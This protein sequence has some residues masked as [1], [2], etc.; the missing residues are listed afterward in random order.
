LAARVASRWPDRYP[1]PSVELTVT[2][3]GGQ[4]AFRN[5]TFAVHPVPVWPRREIHAAAAPTRLKIDGKPGEWEGVPDATTFIEADS[6]RLAE[7]ETTVRLAR[8][9]KNLYVLAR[10]QMGDAKRFGEGAED[11]DDSD[12]YDEDE[13]FVVHL[14]TPAHAYTF[15]VNTRKSE[16]DARDGDR[17]WNGDFHSAV[18][19]DGDHW[20]A[21]LAIPLNQL[22]G[23]PNRVNFVHTDGKT[24][25]QSLWVPTFGRSDDANWYGFLTAP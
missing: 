24:E 11:R 16:Y 8:D 2:E 18:A 14:G 23:E 13:S 3:P 12:I 10:L 15:G 9:E 7:L 6:Q 4:P 22:D 1:L 5:R 20:Y 21:E 19:K 17:D 25:T